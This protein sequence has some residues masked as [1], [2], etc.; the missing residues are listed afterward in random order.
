MRA[1]KDLLATG[2]IDIQYIDARKEETDDATDP[3]WAV[4][5]RAQDLP[6]AFRKDSMMTTTPT[7]LASEALPRA[8]GTRSSNSTHVVSRWM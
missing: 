3:H 6:E 2:K 4:R 1:I 8:V 5:E 7:M